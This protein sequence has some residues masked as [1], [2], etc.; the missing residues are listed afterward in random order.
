M[1]NTSEKFYDRIYFLYPVIDLF[2]APQKKKLFQK[3]NAFPYG[4]LLEVGVGDGSHL[5]Y[6]KTHAVIGID[7]SESMISRA[8][9]H[10]PNNIQ[11][12]KMNGEQLLFPNGSF[13]Y[14]VLS[15]VIAVVDDPEKL[16][17]EVHRV[18]KQNGKIFILN[19]FTPQNWLRH[20]DRIFQRFSKLLHLKSE[21]HMSSSQ[22]TKKFTLL[23]EQDVGLF[24]YFKILIYEKKL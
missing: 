10:A 4:T 23:E 19:H 15:H 1:T 5:G 2:L 14:V 9:Q 18:L 20:M 7:A 17:E 24:S 22:T 11:L 12:L 16:I 3:V 13:D 8:R 6:Y 21:F